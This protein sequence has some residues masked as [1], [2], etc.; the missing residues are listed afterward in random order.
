MRIVVLNENKMM[1]KVITKTLLAQQYE[2]IVPHNTMEAVD[3][4]REQMPDLVIMDL[5]ISYLTPFEIIETVRSIKGKYIQILLLSKVTLKN[6][7]K[8]AIKLGADDFI[9]IPLDLNELREKVRYVCKKR[10]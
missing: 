10:L 3:M 7:L 6:T 4:I 8:D 9:V 5:L 1:L 2:V